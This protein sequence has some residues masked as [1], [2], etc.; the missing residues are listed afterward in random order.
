MNPNPLHIMTTDAGRILVPLA[1][2]AIGRE[3]GLALP[4]PADAA[5]LRTPGAAFVTLF[6]KDGELRG[7]IGTLEAHR[8]LVD[9]V[10]ANAV[11][12]AFRDPRFKPLGHDEFAAIDIEVSLLSAMEILHFDDEAGAL[13]QLRPEI[14]G[15]V[16]QFGR[17]RS[18][19]LPQVW[20]Q[21]PDR[22]EFIAH[23]K[24]KAGLPP[25]FWSNEMKLSCY[26]VSKWREA[27]L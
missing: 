11:A 25:D 7:C 24:Y 18:T 8:P 15:V 23:L 22:A 10:M 20:E 14:D 2:A 13:T 5:W 26:T 17:H 19:F 16:L 12:A 9:D 1:R 4:A 6:N 27:D 3:L 21:F